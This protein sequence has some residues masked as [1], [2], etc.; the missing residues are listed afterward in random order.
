MPERMSND[1][2][3]AFMGDDNR[4]TKEEKQILLFLYWTFKVVSHDT[5]SAKQRLMEY[6][7]RSILCEHKIYV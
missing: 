4:F 2:I 7:L 3:L 1:E 6:G 5:P